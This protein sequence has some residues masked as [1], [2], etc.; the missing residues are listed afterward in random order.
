MKLW[1]TVEDQSEY[2][3]QKVVPGG[4]ED[5]GLLE[6]YADEYKPNKKVVND[7]NYLGY[8]YLIYTPFRYPPPIPPEHAA[9]FRP[10]HSLKNVFYGATDLNTS[11]IEHAFYFMRERRHLAN[12][13]GS[14][15]Q[16]LNFTVNF[17]ANGMVDIT[18]LPN[19]QAIMD[20]RDRSA[21]NDYIKQ[22]PCESLL[23]PSARNPS[24]K[25][26]ACFEIRKLARNP[27]SSQRLRFTY[28]KAQDRCEVK[29]ENHQLTVVDW[30]SVS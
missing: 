23:Y 27:S 15:E 24:G 10:P 3:L 4:K 19:I 13:T 22:N 6:D 25:C 8:H 5:L 18:G 29:D 11:I 26:V 28:D 1:R 20:R 12:P 16:R 17:D 9:R 21:S 7:A 30:K 2:A 14:G